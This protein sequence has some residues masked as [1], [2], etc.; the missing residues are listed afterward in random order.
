MNK[1]VSRFLKHRSLI[2]R[3]RD[4]F[5]E[6]TSDLAVQLADGPTGPYRFRLVE[7]PCFEIPDGEQPQVGRPG[8]REHGRKGRDV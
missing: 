3:E 7:L 5:L 2:P 4:T 8:Q 6:L 1:R